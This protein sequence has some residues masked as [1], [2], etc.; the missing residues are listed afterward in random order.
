M[1]ER[2]QNRN[3]SNSNDG[4]SMIGLSF[5]SDDE[6]YDFYNLYGRTIGFSIRKNQMTI[7]KDKIVTRRELTCS[8]EGFYT[9]KDTPVKKR[10]D[11]RTGCQAMLEVRRNKENGLYVITKFREE[12]NHDLEPISRVHLLRSQRDFSDAQEQLIFKMREAGIGPAAIFAYFRAEA[13]GSEKVNFT[14]TDCNNLNQRR[15]AEFLKEGDAT[16]LLSYFKSKEKENKSFYYSIMTDEDNRIRGCF[17][18]DAKSKVDYN[19]FGDVVSFDTTF[20]TNNYGMVCAPIA[21]VN[22]H[23]QTVLFGCGLLSNETTDS[24]IWLFK[25]FMEA[26]GGKH[27]QVIFTDRDQAMANAIKEVFPNTHHRLCLWHIFL[28][29]TSNLSN[30]FKED[31]CFK[32]GL[33]NCIYNPE[34]IEEF[35]ERWNKLLVKYDLVENEWLKTLYNSREKWAMVYARP[36]FCAGMTTTQRSESANNFLK[37]F[38]PRT[39]VLT[40]FMQQFDVVMANRRDKVLEV[41][42]RKMPPLKTEWKIEAEASKF[43]TRKIFEEFQAE[44]LGTIGLELDKEELSEDGTT[45]TYPVKYCL[46][47]RRIRTITYVPSTKDVKCSCRKFEF[48]GVLCGHVLKLLIHLQWSELPPMYYLNRWGKNAISGVVIDKSGDVIRH[49]LD[50]AISAR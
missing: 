7:N 24:F 13:G 22:N 3:E 27:P 41:A 44:L 18:C 4:K 39:I 11:T 9:K 45:I 31:E 29:A 38:T 8:C 1:E 37:K 46:D 28:N 15:R 48:T 5:N 30:V 23:G 36:Y 43:Y 26:M 49:E 35:E 20:N 40:E 17:W 10:A 42:S 33:K 34:T 6:A 47:R 25:E 19:F 16:S 2:Q 14:R 12:H 21:G 32:K 50:P